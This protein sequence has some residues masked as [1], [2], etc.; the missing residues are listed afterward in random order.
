MIRTASG[1]GLL[2]RLA[3]VLALCLPLVGLLG[4]ERVLLPGAVPP[5]HAVHAVLALGDSV[6]SGRSCGCS[7]F[8]Q[9]YGDELAART[10]SRVTVDNRAVSGIDTADLAAQLATAPVRDAVRRSDV[11]L[12]TIGANDFGDHHDEVVSGACAQGNRDC[13]ADELDELRAH[14]ASALRTIHV[15]RAG[16]AAPT[17]VLVTGYW[18]VFEDGDVARRAFGSSGLAEALRLT[19]RANAVI[20]TVTVAAGDRYVDLLAAFQDAA[21]RDVTALV[22][23][24]G[25]HPDAEGHAVIAQALLAAGLAGS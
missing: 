22:A 19:R 11:V 7:P 9:T 1:H 2:V 4:P 14:L 21:G 23:A 10:G 12:L 18:N 20:R 3:T 15:L 6:P 5:A 25:D 13:V 8:P 17:T 16:A 24:D